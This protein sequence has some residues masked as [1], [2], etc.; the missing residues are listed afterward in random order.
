MSLDP[1]VGV[2]WIGGGRG[3]RGRGRK[4]RRWRERGIDICAWKGA[5]KRLDRGVR[6]TRKGGERKEGSRGDERIKK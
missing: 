5:D 6:A 1:T 4:E 3:R 2:S